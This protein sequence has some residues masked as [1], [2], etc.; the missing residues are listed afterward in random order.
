MAAQVFSGRKLVVGGEGGD[1]TSAIFVGVASTVFPDIHGFQ[2][3]RQH[4]ERQRRQTATNA[5][6]TE[7]LNKR[8]RT[9]N[10]DVIIIITIR[11]RR[12][13]TTNAAA[14][15]FL[16]K[17]RRTINIDVIIIITIRPRRQTTATATKFLNKRRRTII[18]IVI[19]V[20]IVT[21]FHSLFG[22]IMNTVAK[23]LPR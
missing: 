4:V 9:I 6:A 11:P 8:R 17:R 10:I 1:V 15:E 20:T 7:F 21:I 18:V 22:K 3:R 19:F 16:N 2:R 23:T 5:T 12:Q 13:T 14:T